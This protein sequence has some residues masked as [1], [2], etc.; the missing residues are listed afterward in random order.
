VCSKQPEI[1]KSEHIF[2]DLPKIT[3]KLAAWVKDASAKGFWSQ[4]SIAQTNALI[5]AGLPGR[6][7]TRDLKWGTQVPLDKYKNKVFYVWFDAPIGYIS[8][9]ANYTDGWEKWWKN[10]S[11]VESF[12]F[13]GKD[14]ITFHTVIFPS[15]LIATGD[16]FTKLHHISTTEFLNYENAKFS[17][18]RKTGVFGDDAMN[19]GVPVEV[20]R[21]YLLIN[22]PEA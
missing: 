21:Y 11:E 14:N 1:R 12:Q 9:T 5:S 4:N 2:I 15:T 10:P 17:K 13:M 18:T 20:W 22:R 6:C 8:I 3:D 7:I 16:N 19:T